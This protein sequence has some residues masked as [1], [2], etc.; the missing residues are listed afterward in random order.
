M[1]TVQKEP[2]Y[3]KTCKASKVELLHIAICEGEYSLTQTAKL[4]FFSSQ[5]S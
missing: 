3:T 5:N 1:L 4:D 2:Q